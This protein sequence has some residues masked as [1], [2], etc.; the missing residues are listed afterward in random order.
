MV[1]GEKHASSQDSQGGSRF[2]KRQG[3]SAMVAVG[4]MVIGEALVHLSPGR[5]RRA[6]GLDSLP[7]GSSSELSVCRKGRGVEAALREEKNK[8]WTL[9]LEPF[10]LGV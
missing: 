7:T 1:V 6:G 3:F 10:M 8:S 5:Q 9:P 4:E 2:T